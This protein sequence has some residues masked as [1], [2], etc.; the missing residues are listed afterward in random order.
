VAAQIVEWQ[1]LSPTDP[2][3][4]IFAAQTL[5]LTG[6]AWRWWRRPDP[7]ADFAKRLLVTAALLLAPLGFRAVRHQLIA[8]LALAPALGVLLPPRRRARETDPAFPAD[9]K[10]RARPTAPDSP[11]T[12]AAFLAAC[13]AVAAG[14]VAWAWSGPLPRLGWRPISSAAAAAIASCPDPLYNTYNDGGVLLWFVPGKRVFLDS[15]HDPYPHDLMLAQLD[16]DRTGAYEAL[17]KRYAIACAV[18]A[19]DTKTATRLAQT[20]WRPSYADERWAV[21]TR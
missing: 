19:P 9:A 4:L 14:A 15:R 1:P 16:V 20:G 3:D 17:F 5:L 2:L 10:P 6:L 13:G 7:D 21:F 18:V 8:A 12:N 11:R